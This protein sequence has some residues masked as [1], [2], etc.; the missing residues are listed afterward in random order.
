MNRQ[1]VRRFGIVFSLFGLVVFLVN[2]SIILNTDFDKVYFRENLINL[3]FALVI[4]VSSF[5]SKGEYI[6]I[7][8]LSLVSMFTFFSD[9]YSG[10]GLA[11]VVFIA[12]LAFKYGFLLKNFFIKVIISFFLILGTILLSTF[13]HN[14]PLEEFLLPIIFLVVFFL[15]IFIVL[16]E[17]INNSLKREIGY[18]MEIVR[19]NDSLEDSKGLLKKVGA[20][21]IDPVKAGLTIAERDLLEVL[22]IYRESNIDL[23]KRLGKSPNTIKVQMAKI[24]EKIGAENRYQLIDLCRNY[25]IHSEHLDRNR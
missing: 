23:G 8:A 2:L 3:L 4:F 6:H 25:Y 1:L 14:F 19:L 7:G 18:K 17:E 13:I 22:C 9:P 16:S 15:F 5:Y 20:D 21:F 11:L 12:L 10:Y 24:M